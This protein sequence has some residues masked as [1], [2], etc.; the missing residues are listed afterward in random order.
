M[1]RTKKAVR[2]PVPVEVRLEIHGPLFAKLTTK[3]ELSGKLREALTTSLKIGSKVTE[4]LK[5]SLGVVSNLDARVV[6]DLRV[7]GKQ[8]HKNYIKMLKEYLKIMDAE[9]D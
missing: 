3:L 7:E 2:A 8:S 5:A 6:K 9:E 4:T 1:I